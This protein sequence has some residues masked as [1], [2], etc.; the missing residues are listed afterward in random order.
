MEDLFILLFILI[1][2][3]FFKQPRRSGGC[4]VKPR[5]NTPKPDVRPAPQPRSNP[6]N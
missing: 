4:N 6:L 5:S 3:G 1:V 2:L